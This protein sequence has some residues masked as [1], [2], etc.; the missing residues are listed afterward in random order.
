MQK[1]R[2]NNSI[3]RGQALVEFALVLPVLLILTML[4]VQY[5]IIFYA[6]ISLTNLSREGAR[7][8][9]T[10]PASSDSDT[11]NAQKTATN[12]RMSQVIPGN[13]RWSDVSSTITYHDATSGD[14]IDA[15][16]SGALVQVTLTY[17]MS[18]KLFLPSTFLGVHIFNTNYTT[19][20]SM[21]IE[22]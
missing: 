2:L 10:L 16:T 6:T 12:T 21:M 9:A 4:I 20:T 1:S 13:I 14:A 15:P 3:R 5:G 17:N 19:S 22:S 18:R 7:Y 8:A 11:Y